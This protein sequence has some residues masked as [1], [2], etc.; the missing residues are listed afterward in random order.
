[1]NSRE[2]C[3]EKGNE[4]ALV[5]PAAEVRDNLGTLAVQVLAAR[6]D[7]SKMDSC[8]MV[9][10]LYEIVCDLHEA[11]DKERERSMPV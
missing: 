6:E 8:E 11:Y 5:S 2:F 7:I 10:K 1:M 4:H 3:N 9:K